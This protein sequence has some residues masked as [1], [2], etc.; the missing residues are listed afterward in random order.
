MGF[1]SGRPSA[2]IPLP[3]HPYSPLSTGLSNDVSSCATQSLPEEEQQRVLGEE[4]M[5]GSN[6]K[7]A[8]SPASKKSSPET[9]KVGAALGGTG[10]RLPQAWD[11]VVPLQ[12]L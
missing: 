9:G 10:Q 2:L 7:G 1:G 5:L 8:T 11:G 12:G 6:R 3:Q 4:K